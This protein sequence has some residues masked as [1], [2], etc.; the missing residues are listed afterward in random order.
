MI[1]WSA[2]TRRGGVGVGGAVGFEQYPRTID[3]RVREAAKPYIPFQN[4]P[5]SFERCPG[6]GGKVIMPCV[7]CSIGENLD[8]PE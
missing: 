3:T 7:L 4:R 2:R 6:C 1:D 8:K 5:H